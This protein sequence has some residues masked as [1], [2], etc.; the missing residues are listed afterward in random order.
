MRF[1]QPIGVKEKQIAAFKVQGLALILLPVENAQQKPARLQ[2]PPPAIRA[3]EDRGI[4][5]GITVLK[6]ARFGIQHAVDE[7]DQK[8]V[9]EVAMQA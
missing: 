3:H 2:G 4:M 8:L 6:S 9:S 5:T 1:G 7:R